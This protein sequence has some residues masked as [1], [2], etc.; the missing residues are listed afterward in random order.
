MKGGVSVYVSGYDADLYDVVVVA[1]EAVVDVTAARADLAEG[2]AAG[3]Y[4]CE[5]AGGYANSCEATDESVSRAECFDEASAGS[6][7]CA[8]AVVTELVDEVVAVYSGCHVCYVVAASDW[9]AGS[10]D[11]SV[12]AYDEVIAAVDD[13]ES[14]E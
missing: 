4:Y 9:Y 2:A 1:S 12:A 10:A 11:D 14:A 5:S 7:S 3:K 13:Y 8:Y 6:G